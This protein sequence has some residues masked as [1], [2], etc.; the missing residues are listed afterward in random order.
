MIHN[1]I[2][3]FNVAEIETYHG[4]EGISL[5]RF[6]RNVREKLGF[7]GSEDGRFKAEVSTGCEI[8]F[9]TSSSTVRITLSSKETNGDILVYNGDFFHSL[10]RLEAGHIKTLHLNKNKMFNELSE[11]AF[12]ETRFSKDVW[13]IVIGRGVFAMDIFSVIFYNIETFG[14]EIRAPKEAEVPALKWLAYGSSIT[15]GSGATVNHNTYIQQAARR[16]GVDVLNKGIGGSCYCEPEMADYLSNIKEWDFATLEIGVNMRGLFTEAEFEERSKYLI[17]NILNKNPNKH[18]IL[19][20]I[21]PNSSDYLKNQSVK[22][23]TNNDDFR[24]ILRKLYQEYSNPY[25]HLIE[26]TEILT[27]FDTLTCDLIHPSDYGHITMGYNLARFLKN[28]IR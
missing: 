5:Q 11:E 1:N 23:T 25:L 6:P 26:G 13:R 21:F 27:N 15:H 16:L 18:I 10:H 4:T 2:E 14:H 19:I 12:N 20:T 8:R 28:I 9:V 17:N 7:K 3:F 22:T 24:K